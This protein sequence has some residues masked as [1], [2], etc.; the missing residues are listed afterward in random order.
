MLLY[1]LFSVS[2][3]VGGFSVMD[4]QNALSLAPRKF[5]HAVAVVLHYGA[6][7]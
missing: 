6:L 3:N 1:L 2:R 5:K 4:L 7:S